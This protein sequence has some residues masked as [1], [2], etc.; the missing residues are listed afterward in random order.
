MRHTKRHPG[1]GLAILGIAAVAV[2]GVGVL[3]RLAGLR[4]M[5]TTLVEESGDSQALQGFTISGYT[6]FQAENTL[7]H[8]TLQSGQLTGETLPE[9]VRMPEN[10]QLPSA[11]SDNYNIIAVAPEERDVVNRQA[12]FGGNTATSYA[13]NFWVMREI[14]LPDN[15]SL[16]LH[17]ADKTA[18]T[19]VE[20]VSYPNARSGMDW[21]ASNDYLPET[22]PTWA[23]EIRVQWNGTWMIGLNKESVLYQPGIWRVTES[24]T[25]EE[26]EALPLDGAVQYA[27][28]TINVLCKS[29]EYG[30]VELFYVPQN[31]DT[32]LECDTLGEYLGILYR[33]TNG[34]IRFDLVDEN[35]VC[36]Q[37]A[38]ILEDAGAEVSHSQTNTQQSD[39]LC[40]ILGSQRGT[41][42]WV[43]LLQTDDAG[44]LD[45]LSLLGNRLQDVRQLPGTTVIQR[46]A[47]GQYVLFVGREESQLQLTRL[48]QEEETISY[49]AGY[50]VNVYD[51]NAQ[52]VAYTG[53]LDTG[54]DR[55]WGDYIDKSNYIY[56]GLAGEL[57]SL[58][59][60]CY[61]VFPQQAQEG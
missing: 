20:V 4:R 27:D 2:L 43:I 6:R 32:I 45:C 39:Q 26:V 7:T 55:I 14:N 5:Q 53:L 49:S 13:K 25:E 21:S 23:D 1:L 61:T 60:D 40:Y 42:W 58:S 34:D 36:V 17:I 41:D 19:P 29:T 10:A 18:D 30:K 12:T 59:R 3:A 37:Q 16:R 9:Q 28:G 38:L 56:Y 22:Y 8:F 51:L 46:S 35:A 31:L 15:T 52:K 11:F 54:A 48:F 57:L 24:M 50:R 47:D 44:R 33:D